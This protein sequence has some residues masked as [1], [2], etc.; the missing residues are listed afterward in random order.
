M[1]LDGQNAGLGGM[2]PQMMQQIM[3]MFSQQQQDPFS[4][5]L[6]G[7][8]YLGDENPENPRLAQMRQNMGDIESFSPQNEAIS[9]DFANTSPGLPN[10][11]DSLEGFGFGQNAPEQFNGGLKQQLIRQLLAQMP[12]G[13]QMPGL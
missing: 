12:M 3:A 2:S 5:M 9:S 8:Q 11:P 7:E 6:P 10:L 4:Q 13:Q 1:L